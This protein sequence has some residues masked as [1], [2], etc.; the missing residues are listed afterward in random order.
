MLEM[1]T[2]E[3]VLEGPPV[4]EEKVEEYRGIFLLHVALQDRLPEPQVFKES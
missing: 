1:R 4:P 3:G 2:N